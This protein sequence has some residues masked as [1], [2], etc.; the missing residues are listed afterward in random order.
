MPRDHSEIAPKDA[1]AD[2]PA[3]FLSW[4]RLRGPLACLSLAVLCEV[5]VFR[6]LYAYDVSNVYRYDGLSQHFAALV[7]FRDAFF[8]FLRDP[9]HGFQTWNWHLGLGGDIPSTLSYYIADP[10]AALALFFPRAWIEYVYE[11]AYY[12]RIALGSVAAYAYMRKMK[13][14]EFGAV[15]G[16]LIFTFV[17]YTMFLALRHPFFANALIFFPLILIGVER[18]LRERKWG[19]LVAVVAVASIGNFYSFYQMSI[20]ALVYGVAR[21]FEMRKP[22]EPG[23]SVASDG[24]RVVGSY[25]HGIGV[26]AIMLIP[27]VLAVLASSRVTVPRPLDLL[28]AFTSIKQYIVALAAPING[29]DS[30]YAG[31]SILSL[32][33][34]PV[35]FMRKGNRTLKTML[36]LFPI[37]LLSPLF[38]RFFNGFEF[39]SYRFLFMWGMFLGLAAAILLSS[40]RPFSR[41]E[42]TVMGTVV[43]LY[44]VIAP[45]AAKSIGLGFVQVLLIACLGAAM[46]TVFAVHAAVVARHDRS[47]PDAPDSAPSLAGVPW[48]TLTRALVLFLVVA[49]IATAGVELYSK[50]F[51]S[52]VDT[53]IARGQVLKRYEM[54]PGAAAPSLGGVGPGRVE[55]Q[56]G[57]MGSDLAD[58]STSNEALVLGYW[59]TT[60]YYSLMNGKL[61]A[62]MNGLA[63]RPI[64]MGFDFNGFDDR[65]AIDALLGV[66]YYIAPAAG[67]HYVPFG[68]EPTST[69]G[70]DTVYENTNFLPLGYVYHRTIPAAVYDAMKPLE[71]QQALLQGVVVPDGAATD[72]PRA[73]VASDVIDVPYTV[74]AEPGTK[75]DTQ[76]KK[77]TI[78][79]KNT[80]LR[81][82]FSAPAGCEVYVD[83]TGIVFHKGSTPMVVNVS[84]V[85]PPKFQRKLA[86]G[87][88]YDWGSRETLV[89]L[90]YFPSGTSSAVFRFSPSLTVHYGDLKVYAVPMTDF[91]SRVATLAA[92]GMRDI[93]VGSD[94]LSG[95]VTSHGAGVLFL[96]MPYSSGWTATVDGVPVATVQAN[97]GFT[98]IPLTDGTHAIEMR[99]TTPGLKTG[100][101]VTILSLLLA[102][103]LW[104]VRPGDGPLRHLIERRTPGRTEA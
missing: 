81:L 91:A 13:A 104:L 10:F 87:H 60:Y 61:F 103:G 85:G 55:L 14:S 44:A 63:I 27:I 5:L 24:L 67:A 94:A 33:L 100:A 35:I 49:G 47:H 90:G 22:G 16:S 62:F 45:L 93:R 3:R 74:S 21:L 11:G 7:F 4:K 69:V 57:I 76:A 80:G 79:K 84:D 15:V 97:V 48:L 52:V 96:S 9:L 18:A 73:V 19:L 2:A 42:L 56:T 102:L 66:R 50:R 51:S 75:L 46:W 30:M 12:L 82:S 36:V 71:K 6:Y 34:F 8:A 99:Y 40:S 65:A 72:V 31:F 54:S 53:Y 88:T 77:I 38:G 43:A 70:A 20:I 86:Q 98:G 26:A 28:V 89:N 37:F 29:Q 92:D 23:R 78:A 41:K 83:L 1:P 59:G 95:T 64:G 101:I 68:F 17:T 25:L 39:P 32:M 58:L